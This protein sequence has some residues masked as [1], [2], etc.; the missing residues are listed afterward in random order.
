MDPDRPPLVAAVA[1]ALAT[2]GAG[3]GVM[4]VFAVAGP[5]NGPG[6]G[7][8]SYLA[9]TVGD[10][11]LLP[12][13]TGSLAW[14][15]LQARS[16]NR[17]RFVVGAVGSGLV[18]VAVQYSWWRGGQGPGNWTMPRPHSF[19]APGWYH[20]IFFVLVASLAGGAVM[21]GAA[22]ARTGSGTKRRV[23]GWARAVL[24]L[25]AALAC[26]LGL[27]VADSVP[28]AS[29]RSSA[30]T[31]CACLMGATAT[32]L[33]FTPGAGARERLRMVLAAIAGVGVAALIAL[34]RGAAE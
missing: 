31:M 5:W 2:F 27:V 11:L 23:R 16:G 13:V 19:S 15:N 26:F 25:V 7:H 21:R 29:T 12:G 18:A 22:I 20:A 1:V 17:A 32:G 24:L 3:F 4:T 9:G 8:W 10:A 34:V 33:A 14:I 28:T 6:R 30:V